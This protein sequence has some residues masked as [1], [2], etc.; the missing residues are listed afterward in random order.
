M[1]TDDTERTGDVMVAKLWAHVRAQSCMVG[2]L[3]G[4]CLGGALV[5]AGQAVQ[6]Y[7]SRLNVFAGLMRIG[8]PGMGSMSPLEIVAPNA[9]LVM[10]STGTTPGTEAYLAGG[11]R[12][13]AG[14]WMKLG[15]VAFQLTEPNTVDGYASVNLHSTYFYAPGHTTDDY[16]L[17]CW[18][19]HG[20]AMW[21]NT[22]A[23]NQAPGDRVLRVNGAIFT[24]GGAWLSGLPTTTE[25]PN[26]HV[27]ETG[28][29]L[30]STYARKDPP[31]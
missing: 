7:D 5:V 14:G 25:P 30:R 2:V 15:A 12:N 26:L 19:G 24:N 9:G 8:P 10:S 13:A 29:I 21:P 1:N 6:Y 20:C 28:E 3:L 23:A 27:S 16:Q 31:K 22:L 4:M 11:A 17:A 18:G